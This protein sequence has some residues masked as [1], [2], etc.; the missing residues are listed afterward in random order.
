[1]ADTRSCAQCGIVFEPRREHV[2]FCS[3]ECRTAWNRA[4]DTDPAA[5]ESALEWSVTAM[6][7][8]TA[9]LRNSIAPDQPQGLAVIGEAVWWVTI[10]DA[11]MI[12][13]NPELYDV[14]LASH[15]TPERRRIEGTLG[16]LRFVRN[17][18]GVDVDGSDFTKSAVDH[19]GE[20]VSGW[21]WRSMPQPDFSAMPPRGREWAQSRYQAYQDHLAGRTIGEA[22]GRASAFLDLAAT[23]VASAAEAAGLA[24]G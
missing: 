18:M 4:N 19:S 17:W 6:R 16:G 5:E 14:V 13:H 21:T 15:R 8:V 11:T 1:M 3:C 23:K 20:R 24:V 10:V 7:E 2:R 22:F 12:R 9:R